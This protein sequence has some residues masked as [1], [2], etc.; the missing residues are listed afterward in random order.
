MHV[1]SETCTENPKSLSIQELITELDLIITHFISSTQP[2]Y[3]VAL[4]VTV[5]V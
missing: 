1:Y 5:M 3:K 4:C 2:L